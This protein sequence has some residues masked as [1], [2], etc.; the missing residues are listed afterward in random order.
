[1]ETLHIL[2]LYEF[3]ILAAAVGITDLYGINPGDPLQE[4][5][6]MYGI[7]E[8][9]RKGILISQENGFNLIEPYRTIF[10]SI[11][12]ASWILAV[13]GSEPEMENICFYL[14]EKLITLEE[15]RQDSK[16]LRI[17]VYE[18]EEMFSLLEERGF[19]PKPYLEPDVSAIQPEEELLEALQSDTREGLM[20]RGSFFLLNGEKGDRMPEILAQYLVF[21]FGKEKETLPRKAFYLLSNPCNYWVAEKDREETIFLH[22]DTH[23][24]Y[25]RILAALQ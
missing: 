7:H 5:T 16:A 9:V 3:Q 24:L 19:L 4:D 20:R 13:T 22:Y 17:G 11:K 2:P 15:S 8:M 10:L 25:E 18:K 12:D 14:G 23:S 21:A 6:L 1:M